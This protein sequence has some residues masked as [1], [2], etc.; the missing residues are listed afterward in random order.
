VESMHLT[1]TD[2]KEK[3][4]PPG[5]FDGPRQVSDSFTVCITHQRFYPCVSEVRSTCRWSS[6]EN[7][8]L[9]VS[10]HI[11]TTTSQ[12]RI[13]YLRKNPEL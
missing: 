10:E 1:R 9:D 4:T 8:V 5:N 2:S 6:A 12:D 11:M 3:R 13:D 7:D